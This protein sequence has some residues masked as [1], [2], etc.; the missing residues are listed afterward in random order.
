[1][2]EEHLNLLPELHRD[3][4]LAGLGDVTGNLAGVFMFFA[5]DLACVGVGTAFGF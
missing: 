4:V 3:V 2:R 1:M 5:G